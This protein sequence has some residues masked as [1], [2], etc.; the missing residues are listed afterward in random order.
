MA[1]Q[2][3]GRNFQMRVDREIVAATNLVDRNFPLNK[4]K[5]RG[6][7]E[8]LL[9]NLKTCKTT[10]SAIKYLAA[11]S[12]KDANRSIE[13]GMAISPLN[14]LLTD[15]LF[16]IVFVRQRPAQNIRWYQ[17]S[18]WREISE[19]ID[20]YKTIKNPTQIWEERIKEM[21]VEKMKIQKHYK[22]PLKR[23]KNPA[24]IPYWPIPGQMKNPKYCN[25]KTSNFIDFLY[26]WIYRD[27]SQQSHASGAGVIRRYSAL[28]LEESQ[29]R[30][31]ALEKINWNNFQLATTI[32]LG[33][34][35]EVNHIGRY[36]R[37]SNLSY[38][39]TILIQY[40]GSAKDLYEKRYQLF[41]RANC[42]NYLHKLLPR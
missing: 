10:Y 7:R 38:L 6:W 31:Q 16:N 21:E 37:G 5:I 2:L 28:L 20:R 18:G 29:N 19:L 8:F 35:T 36:D 1:Q 17:Q 30:E 9:V 26:L 33:I 22:I 13:F 39:W 41:L 14:R 27:L 4:N 23:V 32:L 11:G 40:F 3:L 12:P 42:P 24:L 34:C 15:L 25:T